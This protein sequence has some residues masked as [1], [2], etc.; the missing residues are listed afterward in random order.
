MKTG[1]LL[2]TLAMVSV[3]LFGGCKSKDPA[4][5]GNPT[6]IP[7]QTTVHATISL[8]GASNLAILA[9]SA[10]TSTGATT[11]TGDLGLSPGTS[12]GGFPP[13]ILNGTLHIND[14]AVPVVI[15]VH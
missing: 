12:V 1:K 6:V 15:N 9:G 3:V 8:A 14:V 2:I 11:I 5:S 10:V 7:V 13:G 4:P